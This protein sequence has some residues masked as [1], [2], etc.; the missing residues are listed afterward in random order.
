MPIV[1]HV[2][3]Q[4]NAVVDLAAAF[5]DE[6][7]RQTVEEP[8]AAADVGGGFQT[9]DVAAGRLG[10]RSGILG[11]GLRSG[12]WRR[13]GLTPVRRRGGCQEIQ[14]EL[15]RLAGQVGGSGERTLVACH[16]RCVVAAQFIGAFS[17]STMTSDVLPTHVEF[18]PKTGQYLF[19][20]SAAVAAHAGRLRGCVAGFCAVLGRNAG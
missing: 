14:R 13:R 6:D 10:D 4:I 1:L 2:G 19:T 16:V 8:W 11:L 3:V 15:H 7:E 18:L 17:A 5:A 9:G 12:L 20:P